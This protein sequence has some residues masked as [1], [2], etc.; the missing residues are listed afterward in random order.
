[1]HLISNIFDYMI[2]KI[3]NIKNWFFFHV[4]IVKHLCFLVFIFKTRIQYKLTQWCDFEG[5]TNSPYNIT[6][7]TPTNGVNDFESNDTKVLIKLT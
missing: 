3:E 1:M 2:Y 7:K 4:F 5:N 6:T